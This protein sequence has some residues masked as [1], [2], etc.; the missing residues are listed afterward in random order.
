MEFICESEWT[1]RFHVTQPVGAS[2]ICIRLWPSNDLSFDYDPDAFLPETITEFADQISLVLSQLNEISL[3]TSIFNI[4][5]ISYRA[6]S[7]LPD[8]TVELD[9]SYPGPITKAFKDN[10]RMMPNAVAISSDCTQ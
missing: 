6:R 3:D 4:N 5:L 10:C 1:E 8:P 7:L 9:A 2:Q